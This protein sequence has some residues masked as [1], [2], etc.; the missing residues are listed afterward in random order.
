[1]GKQLLAAKLSL[2]TAES[3]TGGLVAAT[4]T[5]VEG[6][7]DWFDRGFATYSIASKT[8]MLGVPAPLI[9]RHGAVSEPVARAMAEGALRHSSAGLAL[10][11]TGIAGPS[12][13]GE[14]KS[15]GTVC[16]AWCLAKQMHC[17]TVKFNGDPQQVRAQAAEYALK[18]VK[19]MVSK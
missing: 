16:F 17:E 15:V 18:G 11:I 12:D 10:A 14:N 1:M 5:G 4:V 13:G 3:C 2:V 7:G 9:E 19:T 8:E 6:R